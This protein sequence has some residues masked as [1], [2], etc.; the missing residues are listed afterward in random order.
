[1]NRPGTASRNCT[2]LVLV[3]DGDNTLW[4]T[5]RV[6]EDAHHW[7]LE[8]LYEAE[9]SSSPRPSIE[10]LRK[11]DDLLIREAG[12]Q[13]YDF[14]LLVLALMLVQK[15]MATKD[16]V[17]SAVSELRERPSSVDAR[18]ATHITQEFRLRLQEIPSLL[19]S[20]SCSLKELL[21]LKSRYEGRL[22]L[23]LSSEGDEARI[24]PIFECHFG[25]RRVFDVL[26]IVERK[27]EDTLRDALIQGCNVLK[28]AVG[29]SQIEC[30]LAVVGDS[31]ESDIAPGNLV[32]AIT[33]YIPAG[34]K[35]LERFA[36]DDKRPQRILGGFHQLPDLVAAILA[37][38]SDTIPISAATD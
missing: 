6:F 16:A 29:R 35:G 2:G 1:M 26:H 3:I 14:R 37:N 8:S 19:P 4:D 7:L 11:A 33:I 5:N 10:Q 21:R 28:G 20:V 34:Y 12:R 23:I 38:S 25:R 32:G 36:I 27:S 17:S 18:L 31:I 24:R 13:E 22:A 15:G 9:P 30:Q